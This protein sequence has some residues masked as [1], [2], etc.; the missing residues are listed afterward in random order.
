MKKQDDNLNEIID[1]TKYLPIEINDEMKK[2]FIAYAM[3]VNV[4]RAIPDVRDG[5]K[6]VH[7][8]ILFSL[9][10]M[11]LHSDKPYKKCARIVG[12]VMGKYHPH[13]DSAIYDALVR[14]AQP[15]SINMTL[16]DGHGN[17]GSV[18]GDGAA[19]MR[20]TE[21]RLSK[22]SRE[23]LK[24]IDKD[25]VDFYPNYDETEMQPRV[26][27]S[28]FPNFLVNGSSGI[29]VGMATNAP[30]HNL[31]E[32]INA[33]LALIENEDITIDELITHLPAP[34][35]PT[36]AMI[37]SN[38]G[39]TSAYKTGRGGVVIRS[40]SHIKELS[41]GK[42]QI[43]VT[44]IPYQVNKSKL[45]MSIAD[46]V[47]NK[48][49][50]DISDIRD[51]SGREGTRIVIEVKKDR[52][53]QVVLN[54]LY[55]HSQLQTSNGII[56]LALV[57]KTP[58]IL[59][60]KEILTHYL[61]H[62]KDIITRRTA[63]DK[64]KAEERVHIL[65]GLLIALDNI[66]EVIAIIK[67]SADRAEALTNLKERFGLDDI[68]GVAI[69]EMRLQRLTGLEYDKIKSEIDMLLLA[70]ADY[71]DI[72]ANPQRVLDIIKEDLTVIKEKYGEE[73]KTEISFDLS[74][75]N[76]ADLIKEEDVVL[77]L[78]HQ[79]Y[80]K[81][82][83]VT[84]YRA[85][86]RGGRGIASHKTKNDDFV[87]NII[88]T[89][90]HSKLFC[91]TSLGKVYKMM[92]YEIPEASRTAKGRAM[93]NMLSLAENEKV[94]A[95]IPIP[96]DSDGKILLATKNGLIK[97]MDL[98]NFEKIN[99]NGKIAITLTSDDKLI[100]AELLNVGEEV[101]IASDSGKCIRFKESDIRETGRNSMGVKAMKLEDDSSLISMLV[102]KEG[103][104]ILTIT[105][106]GYGKRTAES[107]YKVQGR[108]GKGLKAGTFKDKTGLIVAVKQVDNENDLMCVTN[109]GTLIRS[110]AD[111]INTT[112]R[113]SMGVK[114]MRVA[115][116]E[117]IISVAIVE[118]VSEED[119][120]EEVDENTS[121]NIEE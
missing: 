29:A 89:S 65:K 52:N 75:I 38:S 4:S 54:S 118:K 20:Y 81:R 50:E 68:Q 109:N 76:I 51:E 25:T 69:L 14:L 2:S 66:D 1:N 97:K 83:P 3:A 24:E 78:T 74:D 40:K 16:V 27:P 18:D 46:L 9:D 57:G 70:I 37:M 22:V 91:F 100:G 101:F 120:A 80:I 98:S 15:F 60:L 7:R 93:I 119:T 104:D 67:R 36:G 12:N 82:I 103:L 92:G 30:P 26:L 117:K 90:T 96:K 21:A 42:S 112:G 94:N 116:G 79:G 63:Y 99:K 19:A 5:L 58:K 6:P 33:V 43:I 56:F 39:I 102:V 77:S 64:R 105:E 31:T 113:S 11:G 41:N 95:I 110:S 87:E 72:L 55:K 114:V 10:E 106:L 107:E 62:Q 34:D 85:Q 71:A 48:K 53:A 45:V 73:R 8:R 35:Y 32:A 86:H 17:F 13:G 44:E 49:I 84:E 88:P 23:M 47:K 59:N 61:D 111:E 108:A 121:A 28:R 115:E